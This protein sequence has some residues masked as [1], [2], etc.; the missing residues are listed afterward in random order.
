MCVGFVGDLQKLQI[1]GSDFILV[2][3]DKI[4]LC[5]NKETDFL[6]K[7]NLER[8]WIRREVEV[9]VC[10]NF[11]LYGWVLRALRMVVVVIWA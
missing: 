7:V 2:H 9:K 11:E 1:Y 10:Q 6:L 5:R 8:G 4:Q 3:V